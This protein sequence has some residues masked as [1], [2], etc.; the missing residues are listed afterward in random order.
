MCGVLRSM[1][2]NMAFD[3]RKLINQLR[4]EINTRTIKD[5]ESEFHKYLNNSVTTIEGI[6]GHV[7]T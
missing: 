1:V 2:E 6:Q 4:D 3:I 5:L 7:Y